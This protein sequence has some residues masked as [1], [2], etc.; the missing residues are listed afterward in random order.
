MASLS[1]Y[2]FLKHS[3]LWIDKIWQIEKY[4]NG[5]KYWDRM[6]ELDLNVCTFSGG[7]TAISLLAP[8][9]KCTGRAT[10]LPLTSALALAAAV[11]LAKC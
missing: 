5:S 9:Y 1:N 2:C 8:L 10:A 6:P 7:A 4:H 3:W 11:A